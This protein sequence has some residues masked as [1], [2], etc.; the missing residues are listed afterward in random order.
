MSVHANSLLNC[1]VSWPVFTHFFRTSVSYKN[2]YRIWI[3]PHLRV[4][5]GHRCNMVLRIRSVSVSEITEEVSIDEILSE[6]RIDQNCFRLNRRLLFW[7]NQKTCVPFHQCIEKEGDYVAI[8]DISSSSVI[9]LSHNKYIWFCIFFLV[10]AAVPCPEK[11]HSSLNT[12]VSCHFAMCLMDRPTV[13]TDLS[14]NFTQVSAWVPRFVSL[15][16]V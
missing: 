15:L 16:K 5:D 8:L 3:L 6:M 7:R 13:L 14:I 2:F 4:L 12:N 1:K 10:T 9:I 11:T